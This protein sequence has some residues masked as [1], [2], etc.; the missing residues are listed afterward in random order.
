M[1][2]ASGNFAERS[3]PEAPS[4]MKTEIQNKSGTHE[5]RVCKQNVILISRSD[6]EL[7]IMHDLLKPL[8]MAISNN[9]LCA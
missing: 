4:S 9:C 1:A 3:N 7:K 8:K 2:R 5:E 6:H